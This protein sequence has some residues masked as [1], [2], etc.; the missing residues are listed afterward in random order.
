M[1]DT[2]AMLLGSAFMVV[3]LVVLWKISIRFVDFVHIGPR[4]QVL[5]YFL[6]LFPPIGAVLL[7]GFGRFA[8]FAEGWFLVLLARSKVKPGKG[9]R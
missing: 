9:G 8:L 5:V 6:I 3:I 7:Y 4:W 2:A 1:S